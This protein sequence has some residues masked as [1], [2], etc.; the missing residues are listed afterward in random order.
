MK[1]YSVVA[2]CEPNSDTSVLPVYAR[3]RLCALALTR[4]QRHLAEA[5]A[6]LNPD[7]RA[8]A[9]AALVAL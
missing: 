1:G 7:T 6:R 5:L 3:H 4:Q 2:R 8:V 9:R